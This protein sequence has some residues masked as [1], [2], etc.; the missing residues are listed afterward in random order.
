[1][2]LKAEQM[3]TRNNA[4]YLFEEKPE[5]ADAL[6]TNHAIENEFKKKIAIDIAFTKIPIKKEQAEQ[7]IKLETIFALLS[8]QNLETIFNK[9][10]IIK[11]C[12]PHNELINEA[13]KDIG[14]TIRSDIK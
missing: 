10:R 9:L 8:A 13:L 11:R 3:L 1:M 2:I 4:P 6:I 12:A 7:H 14:D 5:S